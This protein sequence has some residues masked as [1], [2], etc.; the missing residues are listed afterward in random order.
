EGIRRAELRAADA[1]LV[2]WLTD[3][4][5]AEPPREPGREGWRV[6]TKA[7]LLDWETERA[8]R[9]AGARVV[10]ALTGAGIDGLLADLGSFLDARLRPEPTSMTRQRHASAVVDAIAALDGALGE[11]SD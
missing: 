9:Q 6:V 11:S 5:G 2:L 10:S 1:D 7:D 4:T 8:G 3:G